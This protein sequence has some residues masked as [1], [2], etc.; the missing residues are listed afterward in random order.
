MRTMRL[1]EW[2][3][4]VKAS[5]RAREALFRTQ[6]MQWW[7]ECFPTGTH[8]IRNGRLHSSLMAWLGQQLGFLKATQ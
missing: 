4:G 7:G 5:S 3:M 8:D 1:S 2:T 6:H